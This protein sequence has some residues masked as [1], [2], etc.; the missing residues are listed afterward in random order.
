MATSIFFNIVDM[1]SLA[2][3]I[4][5]MEYNQHFK[6]ADRRKKF[7]KDR[8]KQLCVPSIK[9]RLT[10]TSIICKRFICDPTNLVLVHEVKLLVLTIFFELRQKIQRFLDVV[11]FV[12]EE[13]TGRLAKAAASVKSLL[14]MN[15]LSIS[16]FVMSVLNKQ[17]KI[18]KT[19]FYF[20]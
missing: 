4:I 16:E 7:L 10:K 13:S 2:S 6:C 1:A 12:P 5:F 18:E 15:T 3:Y 8:S 14:V 20:M 17:I 11:I 19:N 9:A